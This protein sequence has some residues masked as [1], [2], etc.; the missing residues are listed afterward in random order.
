MGGSLDKFV[1]E[2]LIVGAGISGLAAARQL[3]DQGRQVRVLEKS[4]GVGGRMATRRVTTAQGEVR[5]D[6]GAQYFTSRTPEFQ[7]L[8]APMLRAGTV[9]SWLESIPTLTLG[10]IEAAKADYCYPRYACPD[11]MNTVAKHLAQGLTIH[12]ETKVTGLS[13]VKD[14]WEAI[15]E[16]GQTF[17]AQTL[18]LTPPPTQS[19]ALLSSQSKLEL[20]QV[21]AL[22]FD[23]CLA[24]LAGYGA[25]PGDLPWGM[26]WEDPVISWSAVDSSKR[27]APAPVV[28]VFHSTAQFAEKYLSEDR[29]WII[30]R[31]L[32]HAYQRLAPYTKLD[33][34]RPLWSQAHLWRYAQPR[35]SLPEPY[36]ALD[37]PPLVL[38]GCWCAGGR[39]EG[40]YTAGVQAAQHLL[41]VNDW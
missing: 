26:R 41:E 5:V 16:D 21:Q 33:L 27:P 36:L 4:R 23:P 25:D 32:A 37:A 13:V 15:T 1:D 20:A 7:A 17:T 14:H 3:Q 35:T 29:D 28:L 40:A 9:I 8:L 6:H 34:T 10:K 2:V 12:C 22:T 18:L 11:G 24:V 19:L 31:L 30:E 38:T 39:V